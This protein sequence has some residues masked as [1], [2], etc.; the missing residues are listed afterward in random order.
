[1]KKSYLFFACL[2]TLLLSA[3]NNESTPQ[4]FQPSTTGKPPASSYTGYVGSGEGSESD[5]NSRNISLPAS[6]KEPSGESIMPNDITTNPSGE[7]NTD[8][9]ALPS[10]EYSTNSLEY[11]ENQNSTSAIK[12]KPIATYSTKVYTKT[13]A[14]Q[15]NL[16]IVCQKLNGTILQP[17]EEFSYNTTC[18][19]YNK[20]NGFGKATIFVGD[21]EVQDYGGGVCQL[22]STL[23]NA[24]KKLNVDITERHNHSKKVYYVPDGQDATVSYGSLDFKFK[25]LNSYPLRIEAN[26]NSQTVNVSIYKA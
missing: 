20:E 6:D 5:K 1:M 11:V 22:S 8:I 15:N 2:F 14:R 13:K 18:G 9:N 7:T 25:N 21:K 26:S 19:P 3:C 16:K 4:K 10:S 17:N 12:Q 23:Y 24:V